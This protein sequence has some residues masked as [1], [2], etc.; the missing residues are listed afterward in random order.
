MDNDHLGVSAT[1][2]AFVDIV[3]MLRI[4]G[5]EGIITFSLQL[6]DLRGQ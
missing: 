6:F 3:D 5:H 4:S 1:I 2:M